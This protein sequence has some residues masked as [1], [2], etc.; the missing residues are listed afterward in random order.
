MVKLGQVVELSKG[1]KLI[2]IRTDVK[3][4]YFIKYTIHKVSQHFKPKK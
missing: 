1:I 2:C 3:K 4:F